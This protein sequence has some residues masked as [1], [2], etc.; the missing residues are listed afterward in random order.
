[1]TTGILCWEGIGFGF[2]CPVDIAGPANRLS[3][4]A[5]PVLMTFGLLRLSDAGGFSMRG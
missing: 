3:L 1:M 4:P 2:G 5:S